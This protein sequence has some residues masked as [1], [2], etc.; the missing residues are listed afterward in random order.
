[1][2]TS[3]KSKEKKPKKVKYDDDD[4][5]SDS[6]DDDDK[7]EEETEGVHAK[8]KR[9]KG[10]KAFASLARQ[11]LSLVPLA[12]VLAQQPFMEKPRQPGINRVKL[13][14]LQLAIT[15]GVHWSATSPTAV[16][17]PKL[18]VYLNGSA[19]V[20]LTPHEYFKT[21]SRKTATDREK[22]WA[23]AYDKAFK[24]L[25]RVA[26][27]DATLRSIVAMPMPNVPLLGSYA[28]VLG[29]V[30][31]PLVGGMEYL[32]VGGCLLILQGTRSFGMEPQPDLY[33]T[34]AVAVVALVLLDQANKKLDN[35]K[36]KRR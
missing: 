22:T 12:M 2:P 33:V 35:P 3:K 17:N 30:L 16:R 8:N 1:M 4:D 29:V 19:Q 32:V 34:G 14:P 24:Q 15:G 7:E 13:I 27:G 23:K 31:A 26:E 25:G 36:K 5:Y 28:L 20:L 6:D 9:L 18:G 21:R 11:L 10:R